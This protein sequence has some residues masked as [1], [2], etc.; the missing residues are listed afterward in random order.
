MQWLS[1]SAALVDTTLGSNGNIWGKENF[2]DSFFYPLCLL[3]FRRLPWHKSGCAF[4]VSDAEQR[5]FHALRCLCQPL[6][7]W[8][9]GISLGRSES[10]PPM[11]LAACCGWMAG[12]TFR[13]SSF[14]DWGQSFQIFT[15]GEI[16]LTA[17][18][19]ALQTEPRRQVKELQ[20][21]WPKESN[22]RKTKLLVLLLPMGVRRMRTD[23]G[24]KGS[25]SQKQQLQLHLSCHPSRND[26]Q[27]FCGILSPA[28]LSGIYSD[29]VTYFCVIRAAWFHPNPALDQRRDFF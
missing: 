29:L 14:F 8:G 9:Q 10:W 27:H 12:L 2:L 20:Q 16:L 11:S 25:L 15:S 26:K 13:F 5:F 4:A 28:C 7:A 3:P 6:S 17:E 22:S 19:D 24:E 1:A 21:S 23:A 18:V